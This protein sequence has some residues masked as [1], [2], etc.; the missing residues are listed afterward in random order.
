MESYQLIVQTLT[1]T[2]GLDE[3]RMRPDATF[4]ELEVD[5]LALVELGLIVQERTG[6]QLSDVGV[7]ST[8]GETATALDHIIRDAAADSAEEI[9]TADPEQTGTAAGTGR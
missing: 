9:A 6:H 1:E 2:F 7:A 8:L 4:E 3:H 5:S